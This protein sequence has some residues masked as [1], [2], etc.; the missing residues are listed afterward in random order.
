MARPTPLPS[1]ADH[2]AHIRRQAA[3]DLFDYFE[4]CCEGA[5]AVDGEARVVW[6]T[7]PYAAFLGLQDAGSALGRPVEEVIPNS[8]MREVVEQGQPILLDIMAHGERSLV[9]TRLP[10]RDEDG[11]IAGAVGF[12]LYDDP[13]SLQPV[14]TKFSRLRAELDAARRELAASRGV[15]YRLEDFVGESAAAREV[16]RLAVC[17]ARADATVL[18]L[19]ETGTGKELVAQAVH[20]ASPRA[21]RPFVGLNVAAVPEGLLEAEFFGAAPGAYTGADR[22]GRDGKFKLADGGTLFLDEIGDMPLHLQ[23]KLLRVLQEQEFEP[24]GSN[25][26]ER[27]DVRVIAATSRDLP[28]MVAD[29]RFRADLWYRLNVLPIELPPLRARRDDLPLLVA[30]LLNRQAARDGGVRRSV[31]AAALSVLAA[32]DWPG[33]IRELANV[34]ERAAMLSEQRCLGADSFTRILSTA[35]TPRTPAEAGAAGVSTL[36]Q[37]V[38]AAERAAIRR[39][40]DASGGNKVAAARLLGIS[41][42]TLYEKL[43]QHAGEALSLSR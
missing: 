36:A 39:A 20:A 24:L 3:R 4:S 12:V 33:N 32:Y 28:A 22:K 16:R 1:S 42:A 11:R 30:V 34:L 37:A 38:A 6:I 40:L 2:A 18:L 8:L 26:V 29:G 17:A 21:G 27:I 43:A 10:L 23:A 13:R 19:G 5:V 14:M 41:R 31:D 15:R 25:R 35:G 7:E 9:V